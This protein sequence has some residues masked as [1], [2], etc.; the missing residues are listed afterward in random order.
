MLLPSPRPPKEWLYMAPCLS[1][2]AAVCYQGNWGWPMTPSLWGLLLQIIYT[3]L[4][5]KCSHISRRKGCLRLCKELRATVC[6]QP[7]NHRRWHMRQVCVTCNLACGQS[8]RQSGCFTGAHH[9]HVLSLAP[10]V[11][12]SESCAT[13]QRAALFSS[14][15]IDV[16]IVTTPIHANRCV[17]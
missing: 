15:S 16:P 5:W 17:L 1:A 14:H 3:E 4:L 12:L 9:Q 11:S 6:S 7:L 8:R 2:S 13:L 10:H